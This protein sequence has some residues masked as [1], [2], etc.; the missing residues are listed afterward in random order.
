MKRV[1]LLLAAGTAVLA[2][3]QEV[4]QHGLAFEKWGA[5]PTSRRALR[6]KSSPPFTEAIIQVNPRIDPHGQPCSI[7]FTDVFQHLAPGAD[8]KPQ[9]HPSLFGVEYPGPLA[10]KSLEFSRP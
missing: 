2:A 9:E 4:Q 1:F 3:A 8:A 6:M 10:S 7:R 5:T